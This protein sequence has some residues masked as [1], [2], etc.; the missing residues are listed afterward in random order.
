MINVIVFM[1]ICDLFL[2]LFIKNI[3]LEESKL[4]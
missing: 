4:K 3:L 1:G 2:L